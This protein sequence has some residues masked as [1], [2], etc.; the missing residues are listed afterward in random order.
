MAPPLILQNFIG[1]AFVPTANPS[2][3]YFDS[4]NPATGEVYARV[5][6]SDAADIDAAVDAAAKAFPAWSSTTRAHRSA[7]ML[8]IAQ[9]LEDRL[10]EFAVAES[11]DQGKPVSLARQV[12]IPRAIHNFRFFATYILHME[13]KKTELDHVAINYT[14]KVPVGVAG[15]ISPWNLPLYLATWKLAP[16]IAA[17]CT[18]VLKPSEFTSVT[19]WKLCSLLNEAGLPAGVINVVFGTGPKAGSALVS[20]PKVPLISFTGGTATGE[21]IY[22]NCAPL[23]KKMSL[24]LGGKNANVVFA[25]ADFD[26]AIETSVLSSFRNQGEICLCGS[27]IFVEAPIYD[28]FV[29]E[30]C[31]RADSLVV[32]DP[33]HPSTQLGALV[34]APHMD[35]V[36]S[37]VELAKQEGG[38]IAAGGVRVTDVK[39]GEGGYFMRPTVIT[40]LKASDRVVQEEIFGPV[41]TV[42]PF[43]TEEEVLEY[44]NGTK[45]GLAGS[46][47]TENLRRAHRFAAKV[48]TGTIWV[49]CW[50]VRDLNMPFGGVKASGL[51]REG[52]PYSFD[53]FCDEKTICIAL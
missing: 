35:K 38:T 42:T 8:K 2:T 51:G 3:G 26:K 17:G 16:A 50:M 14:Q 12:D 4:P 19:A 31:K 30:L 37:Y 53:F 33:A 36:M 21:I 25:D 28:R 39:G 32:G 34:S 40:G 20:H 29:A 46:V 45:Y 6:D 44:F 10:E 11:Q 9:L 43:T 24:E 27:R 23:F 7:V 1:G 18:C 41:V 49:N 13:E 52:A 5:P 22:R 48:Q 15:L 47:W